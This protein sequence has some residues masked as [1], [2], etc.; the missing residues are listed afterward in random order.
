[1]GRPNSWITGNSRGTDH[2]LTDTLSIFSYT[3][4]LIEYTT[5]HSSDTRGPSDDT[6][7]T[8]PTITD[9]DIIVLDGI[10]TTRSHPKSL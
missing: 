9:S 6:F 1:M 2:S 3:I 4:T 10:V 8:L 5:L 7:T